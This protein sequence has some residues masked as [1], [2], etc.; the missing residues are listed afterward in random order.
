MAAVAQVRQRR[1]DKIPFK[2]KFAF[3][4]FK[5]GREGCRETERERGCR[6]ERKEINW[7]LSLFDD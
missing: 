1:A 3:N 7:S 4:F 2:G 6:G 5:K